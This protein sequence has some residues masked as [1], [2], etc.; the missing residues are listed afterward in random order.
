M[1]IEP[2]IEKI[3]RIAGTS[4]NDDDNKEEKFEIESSI[5]A[6]LIVLPL[7]HSGYESTV[8]AFE[9]QAEYTPLEST[10]A[11]MPIHRH[12]L[13]KLALGNCNIWSVPNNQSILN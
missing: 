6:G 4:I 9:Q 2:E 5:L 8:P 10:S 3:V 11:R 13:V 7:L 1:K 12:L